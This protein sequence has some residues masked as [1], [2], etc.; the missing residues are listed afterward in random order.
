MAAWGHPGPAQG[1]APGG[2][3][4]GKGPLPPNC[5]LLLLFNPFRV[6]FLGLF[7]PTFFFLNRS[8]GTNGVPSLHSSSVTVGDGSL[9]KPQLSGNL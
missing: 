9:P 4:A 3:E 7:P 5:L 1:T 2:K 6:F 8:L